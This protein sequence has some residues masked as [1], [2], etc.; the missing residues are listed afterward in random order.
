MRSLG[1]LALALLLCATGLGQAQQSTTP[2]QVAQPGQPA[3]ARPGSL[4]PR[5]LRPG[6]A[7]PKGT[8]AIRGQVLAAGTGQP[9]R[10][11]QVRVSSNDGRGSGGVT[12]TD[13]EG[14]FEVKDLAAGRYIVMAAKG[15]YVSSQFG[16]RRPNEPGTPI[17]LVDAQ[18]ADRVNFTLSR[19]GVIAGR[20]VDDGGEPVSG[21]QVMALRYAFTGGSRRL[22]PAGGEGANDRTDDQGGFRLFGLPPGDYYVSAVNR[23][24]MMMMNTSI[25]N[26]EAEGFAPTY[27]PGTPNLGEATRIPLRSGQEMTGANFA[28]TVARMARV[29]GRVLNSRGEPAQT[30]LMLAPADPSQSALY[31]NVNQTM[32]RPDGAFE[33]ANVAAGRYNLQARPMGMQDAN[34]EFAVMPLTVGND[35]VDGVLLATSVG[36]TARGVVVSDVGSALTIRPSELQISA[37]PLEPMTMS[38]MPQTKVNDDFSFVM[39]GLAERRV[40]RAFV[41]GGWFLKAVFHGADDITD[42]GLEFVPGRTVEDIQIV[43]TQKATDLSGLV[44]DDRNRPVVDATVVIFPENRERWTFLSRYQ[45]TA[46]PDIEGRYNVRS[47]PPG[48]AYLI[49]AVQNLENGQAGDPE[50][51]ARAREEAKPFTL[52]EGETKAVDIK[53]SKLV[54]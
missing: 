1:V 54:P 29:R 6:E 42:T 3:P 19:G 52:A 33:L 18:N 41:P 5:V 45:R 51:L 53:L 44:T 32:V 27:Y 22:A 13:S 49:I 10:R 47:L 34:S 28:M 26:T 43:L 31:M 17:E 11:A 39:S 40:I 38:G 46:R 14:R 24:G 4:P 7:P 48:E 25:N 35:D 36:A 12:S 2:G 16:Q 9:I 20:I 50:F 15:G 37:S 30:M 23:S 8:A 21:T